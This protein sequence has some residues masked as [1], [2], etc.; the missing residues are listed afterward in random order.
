MLKFIDENDIKLAIESDIRNRKVNTTPR[1]GNSIS[2]RPILYN[3]IR[4]IY[5]E[6]FDYEREVSDDISAEL[7]FY[8]TGPIGSALHERLQSLT[9]LDEQYYTEKLLTFQSFSPLQIRTKCD[10][11]DLRDPDNIIL[12]EFK[13]KDKMPD[14]PYHEELLQNLLSVFFFFL[15]I[16]NYC[17]LLVVRTKDCFGS[18]HFHHC[19]G[20]SIWSPSSYMTVI[21]YVLLSPTCICPLR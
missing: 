19:A 4:E 21:L 7:G 2:L 8:W 1:N 13:T 15:F 11:I 9:K 20:S 16:F 12:Y 17:F 3:C 5:Y 10:G 18:L 6:I 14:K